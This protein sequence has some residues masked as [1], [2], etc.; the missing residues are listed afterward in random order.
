MIHLLAVQQIIRLRIRINLRVIPVDSLVTIDVEHHSS[1]LDALSYKAYHDCMTESTPFTDP[2]A[3]Q[4]T[5]TAPESPAAITRTTVLAFF[6]ADHAAVAPDAKMYVNGG[7]FGLLR[8]PSFPAQLATFGV[9]AVVEMPFQD[10]MR[11]HTLRIGLRGP[12]QEERPVRVEARFRTAPT[13]EAQYGEPQ[14]I[15]FAVTIPNVEFPAPGVYHLVLWV[16]DAE[17]ATYRLRAVQTPMVMTAAAPLPGSP[18]SS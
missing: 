5:P 8:F 12:E 18:P 3:D 6:A 14:L 2:A 7:F 17:R 15:P 4:D 11:D 13:I 10:T 16:D 1:L 9:G